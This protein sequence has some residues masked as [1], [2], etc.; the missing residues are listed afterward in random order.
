MPAKE[1]KHRK[2]RKMLLKNDMNRLKHLC[3]SSSAPVRMHVASSISALRTAST[4]SAPTAAGPVRVRVPIPSGPNGNGNAL[5]D[6][7]VVMANRIHAIVD[8]EIAA[9]QV[10]PHGRVFLRQFIRFVVCV[11]LVFSVVYSDDAFVPAARRRGV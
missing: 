6:T 1:H 9:N 4:A 2:C 8:R 11:G 5:Y 7:A 3:P 10:R